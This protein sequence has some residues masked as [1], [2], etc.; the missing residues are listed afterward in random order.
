MLASWVGADQSAAPFLSL[1]LSLAA[2]VGA[3]SVQQP[4]TRSCLVMC[5]SGR[6]EVW[7]GDCGWGK[8]KVF[9]PLEVTPRK[10]L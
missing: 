7:R 4:R 5:L 10:G 2:A 3:E 8:S 1:S 6:L 9:L